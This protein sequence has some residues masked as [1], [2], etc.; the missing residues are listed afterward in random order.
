[1]V[2]CLDYKK[3]LKLQKGIEVKQI[4]LDEIFWKSCLIVVEIMG[5]LIRLLRI[6]DS[7]E[8]PAMGYVYDGYIGLARELKN[9]PKIR[10]TCISLILHHQRSLE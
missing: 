8:K 3:F 2:V 9:Y 1:M 5:P 4:V 7:E 6:C 10:G